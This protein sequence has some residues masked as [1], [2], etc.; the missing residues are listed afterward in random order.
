MK[1]RSEV[2]SD[3]EFIRAVNANA[4]AADTEGRIIDRIRAIARP[5][6]SLVA[7]DDGVVGHILFSPVTID[8]A[9][10]LIMGLGPMAVEPSRQRQSIG[11][12]LVIAGL[13]ECRHRGVAGVVVIGHPEFYPRFGF[14]PGSRFGLTC[15]YE[16][17]DDV[18]MAMELI[19]G[20][21]RGKNAQ[22]RYHP[23]FSES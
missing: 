14:I 21:L 12:A 22:V 4:F 7:E 9:D 3:I 10:Q 16:V 5:V 6:I 13:E 23:A 15:E 8:G 17:P 20:S 11:S 1:I 19:D 2:S 18:F